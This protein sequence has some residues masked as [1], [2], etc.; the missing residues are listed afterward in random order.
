MPPA[1]VGAE[2]PRRVGPLGD[3]APREHER[4]RVGR[5]GEAPGLDQAR[6]DGRDGRVREGAAAPAGVS[7][8]KKKE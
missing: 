5:I 7:W 3:V 4:D 8:E 2:R 1:E 6:D